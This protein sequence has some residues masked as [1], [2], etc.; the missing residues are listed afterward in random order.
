MERINNTNLHN[1][2]FL[3]ILGVFS[4][5]VAQAKKCNEPCEQNKDCNSSCPVCIGASQNPHK[6]G[7]CSKLL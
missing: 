1:L 3:A 6:E 5:S 2:V 7:I 4:V